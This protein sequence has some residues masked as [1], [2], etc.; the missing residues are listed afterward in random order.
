[1]TSKGIAWIL[2][3]S[4]EETIKNL[5]S[6]PE[7]VK[8][9]DRIPLYDVITSD[10]IKNLSRL[11]KD[12]I[13]YSVKNILKLRVSQSFDE[14]FKAYLLCLENLMHF[15]NKNIIKHETQNIKKKLKIGTFDPCVDYDR[16]CGYVECLEI[17]LKHLDDRHLNLESIKKY[18]FLK[19]VNSS[20]IKLTDLIYNE[21]SESILTWKTHIKD[22]ISHIKSISKCKYIAK[23][24]N[25]YK[26]YLENKENFGVNK[27]Q[28]LLEYLDLENHELYQ[29]YKNTILIIQ[30]IDEKLLKPF[31]KNITYQPINHENI[32]RNTIREIINT[33]QTLFDESYKAYVETP[34]GSLPNLDCVYCVSLK[35]FLNCFLSSETQSTLLTLYTRNDEPK[36][37][38]DIIQII[39]EFPLSVQ[40][41]IGEILQS[42]PQPFL[43]EIILKFLFEKVDHMSFEL[44]GKAWADLFI[45]TALRPP[46]RQVLEEVCAE[47]VDLERELQKITHKIVLMQM[48]DCIYGM[49]LRNLTISLRKLDENCA[50]K[51]ATF[52][53]YLHELS[54]H[55]ARANSET[56]E[57]SINCKRRTIE[58]PSKGG[59]ALEKRLFGSPLSFITF[60]AANYIFSKG[61]PEDLE[62]FQKT[63]KLINDYYSY[64]EIIK[65]PRSPKQTFPNRSRMGC[66]RSLCHW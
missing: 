54:Y 47:G 15:L 39:K 52:Y 25:S 29:S 56:I 63:F 55:L 45:D 5:E 35:D 33:H 28:K 26:T 20:L 3:D 65:L 38:Y 43:R 57:E 58:D 16:Y 13:Y 24:L 31:K 41:T 19:E 14:S 8:M 30:E 64:G 27:K 50:L 7:Y 11:N 46:F 53:I 34:T 9:N 62:N 18:K 49:N 36:Y 4:I 51:G 2:M 40:Y 61:V 12:S 60:D 32:M 10:A 44:I 23:A 21:D 37:L 22:L 42:L 66:F 48:P 6:D 17:I 59:A 1:M